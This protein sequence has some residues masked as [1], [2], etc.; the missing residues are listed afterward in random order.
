[1]RSLPGYHPLTDVYG[2]LDKLQRD[3]KFYMLDCLSRSYTYRL[4]TT[5]LGVYSYK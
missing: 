3:L 1:M 5:D 4:E 2:E